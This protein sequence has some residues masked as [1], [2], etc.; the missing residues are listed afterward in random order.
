[1]KN[2]L[3]FSEISTT[4]K[5]QISLISSFVLQGHKVYYLNK[6]SSSELAKAVR[7]AGGT[8]YEIPEKGIIFSILYLI[9]FCYKNKVQILYSHLE[10][11]NF[12]AVIAQFFI[13][14]KVIISRHH[15]DLAKYLGFDRSLTYRITYSLAK[16]IIAVS[17]QVKKYM[18]EQEKVKEK[19]I[20]QINLGFDFKLYNEPDY[21]EVSKIKNSSECVLLTIGRLDALKRPDQSIYVLKNLID[22]GFDA[23]LIF[24]GEGDL[25]NE[26]NIIVKK[27]NLEKRVQFA[28][29]VKNIVN[30][31]SAADFILHPS[32]SESSC[33]V[34]KEAGF[35]KKVFL[36]CDGVG[37]FNDYVES[38]K[39]G[40]LVDPLTYAH[41]VSTLICAHIKNTVYLDSLGNNLQTSII[42]NF[43][44]SN[45]VEKYD[46]FHV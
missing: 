33:I 25:Q 36:A 10:P 34:A 14:S 31:L 37:Y 5:D 13:P 39:S 46:Q 27:L 12:A 18:I 1:M 4:P 21:E 38:G 2:I 32:I 42:S 44:V 26:L 15:L 19:K 3:L 8:Y 20:F 43:D 6:T 16:T 7:E 23:K 24:L 28:G 11:A 30:Y 29:Y 9:F 35:F 40:F 41:E 45:V 22:T 17:P